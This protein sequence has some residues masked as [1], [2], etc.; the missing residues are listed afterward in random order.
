VR[1]GHLL[2]DV[3]ARIDEVLPAVG[4]EPIDILEVRQQRQ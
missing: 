1:F 4:A 2:R 3:D